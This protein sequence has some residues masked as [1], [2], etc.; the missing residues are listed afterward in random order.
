MRIEFTNGAT[1]HQLWGVL[2]DG[3]L[4]GAFPDYS[5]A[6]AYAADAIDHEPEQC[7]LLVVDHGTGQSQLYTHPKS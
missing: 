4:I 7:S 6:K 3:V 5:R 1:V 2:P